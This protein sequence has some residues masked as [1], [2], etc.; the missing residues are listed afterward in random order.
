MHR[1]L[2]HQD[3]PRSKVPALSPADYRTS[4]ISRK[5]FYPELMIAF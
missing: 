3:G 4:L 2:Y 5:V 1:K